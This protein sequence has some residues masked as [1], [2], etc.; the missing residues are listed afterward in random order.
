MYLG[1]ETGHFKTP[2]TQE[3]IPHCSKNAFQLFHL[4][5]IIYQSFNLQSLHEKE[6][7]KPSKINLQIINKT[8]KYILTTK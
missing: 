1:E 8:F 6:L 7:D 3:S 2:N 4:A 5:S